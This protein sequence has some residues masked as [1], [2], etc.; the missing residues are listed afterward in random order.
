METL[1]PLITLPAIA[2]LGFLTR[3]T[4]YIGEEAFSHL[5]QLM[6]RLCYPLLIL[7]SLMRTDLR[8]ILAESLVAVLGTAG[9]TLALYLLGKLIFRRVDPARRPLYLFNLSI[10]N[11]VYVTLPVM[12]ALF[13][14]EGVVLTMLC[15]TTQDLF[16]WSLYH[17]EFRRQE[18]ARASLLRAVANPCT[19]ALLLG[20]VLSLL[21][22]P[23]PA[24]L[25][26]AS[27]L[28]S[29]TSPLGMLFIGATLV[30]CNLQTIFRGPVLLTSA[31]K[32]L[33]VPA[34]ACALFFLLTRDA[35]F[36]AIMTLYFASPCA[37]LS[38]V[39]AKEYGRDLDMAA[40]S[41]LVSTVLFFLG[42]GVY[43]LL[44]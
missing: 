20:I 34:L 14:P 15:T 17:L 26:F 23:F 10:G 5:P 32:V 16:L 27:T 21:R 3:K 28:A 11:I 41:V 38:A 40:G 8:A 19:A 22:V 33:A 7:T 39:W 18:G 37:L 25:E 35:G 2:G 4:G 29:L 6:L 30:G 44:R 12:S 31:L 1:I 9:L 42:V 43:A 36:A 24:W 13:G